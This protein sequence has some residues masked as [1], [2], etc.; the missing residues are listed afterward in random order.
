MSE[1]ELNNKDLEGESCEHDCG[2]EHEAE[3]AVALNEAAPTDWKLQAAYLTAEIENMQKRFMREASDIRKYSNEDILK[4][5][6][7]VLDT[8]TFA[9]QAAAKARTGPS[10][11][12]ALFSNKVFQS[13]IH[14]VELTA[15]Q[16]EQVLESS[17]VEFVNSLGQSFD[18]NLHEAL[19][20]SQNADLGDNVISEEF[21]RGF[22]LGGRV[23]RPAK[24]LVNRI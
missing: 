2:C 14:G 9:L 17:G 13:F 4:K 8:L 7:P 16:F 1:K 21:V 10:P 23:I 3:E 18:P 11:D 19:G 20:Q 12:E 5:V 6:V 22:K 24:V 15:K